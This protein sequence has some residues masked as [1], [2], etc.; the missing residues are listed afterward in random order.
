MRRFKSAAQAQRFLSVHG[1][2]QNL[3]RV[4]RHLLRAVGGDLPSTWGAPVEL[5]SQP[6][7]PGGGHFGVG[8]DGRVLLLKRDETPTDATSSG[9]VIVENW[10]TELNDRVP[11]P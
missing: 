6:H 10:L 9:L 3:L 1:P 5:F 2:I 8:P 11:V 7:V 4:G